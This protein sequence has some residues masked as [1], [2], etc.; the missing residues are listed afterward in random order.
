MTRHRGG[1]IAPRD[2]GPSGRYGG[3]KR[4][5]TRPK[6]ILPD[7][8][9]PLSGNILYALVHHLSLDDMEIVPVS[10]RE[11]PP[12]PWPIASPDPPGV[13]A[14]RS[15]IP[16]WTHGQGPCGR[17][18]AIHHVAPYAG[19]GVNPHRIA[20][21]RDCTDLPR[22]APLSLHEKAPGTRI[23]SARSGMVRSDSLC[24]GT[25]QQSA[26]MPAEG[27]IALS[28]FDR[29]G[30]RVGC[31]YRRKRRAPSWPIPLTRVIITWPHRG[32]KRQAS[33][34]K[35]TGRRAARRVTV[36]ARRSSVDADGADL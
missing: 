26:S 8:F 28:E 1:R 34:T 15:P 16:E 17:S 25:W 32:G 3:A 27:W 23:S 13:R 4:A 11:L 14:A 10:H 33:A 21:G 9:S 5:Q 29:S 12:P 24:P 36:T 22:I 31:R 6:G 35:N 18:A 2:A 20:G 30:G 7:A 19:P